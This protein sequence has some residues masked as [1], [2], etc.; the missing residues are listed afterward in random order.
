M[1]ATL[2]GWLALQNIFGRSPKPSWPVQF[3]LSTG[4][5]LGLVGC[6]LFVHLVLLNQIHRAAVIGTV[7]GLIL[8][9]AGL[10]FQKYR[11]NRVP[12]WPRPD[13]GSFVMVFLFV[14]ASLMFWYQCEFYQY[15]GWD[16]WSTW[17]FKAKMLYLGGENW[18]NVFHPLLWR[19]SPHYPLLFPLINAW[20]W[21]FTGEPVQNIPVYTTF[22]FNFAVAGYL[23]FS[24]RDITRSNWAALA[25]FV[26]IT[27]PHFGKLGLSQ[28]ADMVVGYFI[29]VTVISLVQAKQTKLPAYMI[30]AGSSAGFLIFVKNEGLVAAGILML[31][32][33]LFLRWKTP[34][35]A[36]KKFVLWLGAGLAVTGLA[37]L[38]FY[39]FFAPENQTFINGFVSPTRKVTFHRFKTILAFFLLETAAPFWN[40]WYLMSEGHFGEMISKW[41]GIWVAGVVAL[42]FRFKSAFGKNT[43][44]IPVFLTGYGG[45]LVLYYLINTY[46]RIEWWLQ[47]SLARLI[48]ALLPVFLFWIFVTY[49]PPKNPSDPE[50]DSSP[51]V[52]NPS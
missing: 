24:L 35:I 17:N 9:L 32:A 28:Y 1:T 39:V 50:S 23:C 36:W 29:T 45:V 33:P 2:L 10:L 21:C 5:G 30:L 14:L 43:I 3:F 11:R 42:L 7:L 52:K 25:G 13:T 6:V 34:D 22:L 18:K 38:I 41:H 37:A 51:H 15:G 31:L 26:L 19:S 47:V 48:S 40:M 16:A 8:I 20:G 12:F 49:W 4:M 27:Q 44:L 46:F